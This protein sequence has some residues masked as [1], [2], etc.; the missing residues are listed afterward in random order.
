MDAT[1]DTTRVDP[2]TEGIIY[3]TPREAAELLRVPTS[4]IYARTRSGTMPGQRRFGR[5]VR[6]SKVELVRWIDDQR[7]T[8]LADAVGRPVTA[9]RSAKRKWAT[10]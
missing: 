2:A 4:W 9:G 7:E 5:Y 1:H 6:I 8:A 10:R 3:L